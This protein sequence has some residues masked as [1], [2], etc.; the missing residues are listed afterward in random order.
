MADATLRWRILALL[1]IVRTAMAFQFQAVGALSPLFVES[2][3][4]TLADIGLLVGLYL[5]P[6]IVFAL[7]GGAL[8][9]RFGD[10]RLVLV[11]LALM[12]AGGILAVAGYSFAAQVTAR[13][14]AGAGGVILNVLMSK[15]VT[16]WFA[17]R[18]IATAMAIFVNSW[19]VGIALALAVLP[20]V[21]AAGGLAAALAAVAAFAAL[22]FVLLATLY[23]EPPAPAGASAVAAW[24]SGAALGALVTAAALWGLYN[25]ALVMVFSFGPAL[26]TE[27]GLPL[28]AARGT[29]RLVRWLGALVGP[30]GGLIADRTGRRDLVLLIGLVGFALGLM[31]VRAGVEPLLA[32]LLV[33]I[34]AGLPAGPIMSLPATA[35]RPE[36]R[37]AGMGLF[38]T[39]HY[40]AMVTGP[41]LA[42]GIAAAAGTAAVTFDVGVVLLG[43]CVALLW[44]FRWTVALPRPA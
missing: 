35:L 38:F 25:T 19:P 37:A 13:L 4:I 33:G 39:I 31:A 41:Y 22:G 28:A 44:A 16:D 6:G 21:A 29:T 20:L 15:M 30:F 1:F 34:A 42:G 43:A 32:F 24:P 7:P 14:L 8:G 11:G 18:E 2:L 12:V 10:R 40:V 23:R 27:R 26:L 36:T 9:A 3:G 5:A 17:G